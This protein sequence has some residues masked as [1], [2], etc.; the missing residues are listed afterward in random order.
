M[1]QIAAIYDSQTTEIAD[2]SDVA[3]TVIDSDEDIAATQKIP[4]RRRHRSDEDIAATQKTHISSP[5]S[6]LKIHISSPEPPS[7]LKV[8]ISSS[9]HPSRLKIYS[10]S[11]QLPSRLKI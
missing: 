8:Y 11:R 1:E 3:P 4:F 10:S 6:R 9:Q 2:R 5:Q 7:R